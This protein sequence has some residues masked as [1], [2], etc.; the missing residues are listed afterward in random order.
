[1]FTVHMVLDNIHTNIT[2][3]TEKKFIVGCGTTLEGVAIVVL[4][5][6]HFGLWS[7]FPCVLEIRKVIG[8]DTRWV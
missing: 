6:N 2:V 5:G 1:M 8:S 4:T 3:D 7:P